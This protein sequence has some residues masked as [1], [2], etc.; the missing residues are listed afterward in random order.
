MSKGA[1][2]ATV[3]LR[4][5][6]T[7][8]DGKPLTATTSS[9]QSTG[10]STPPT[11]MPAAQVR[12]PQALKALTT[13]TVQIGLNFRGRDL[14]RAL[15]GPA[16]L[17][18]AH[19]PRPQKPWNG[20]GP[21][22]VESFTPGQRSVLKKNPNYWMSGKPYLD[23]VVIIDTADPTRNGAT[24]C[25]RAGRRDR[26][27]PPQRDDRDRG[28]EEPEALT[29]NGGYFQPIVTPGVDLPP[30]NATASARRSA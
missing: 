27:C 8:H 12:Q 13:S 30:F 29:A 15:Y 14:P 5:G 18:R 17:D 20:T 7:W 9:P 4:K 19:E 25:S 1:T 28:V 11:P 6:V 16:A 24:R 26:L 23:S 2:V 3:R 22:M 21:F 10:S